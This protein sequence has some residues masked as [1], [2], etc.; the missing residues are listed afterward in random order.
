MEN[1]AGDSP[2]SSKPVPESV[3]SQFQHLEADTAMIQEA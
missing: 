2:C 3:F 1:S